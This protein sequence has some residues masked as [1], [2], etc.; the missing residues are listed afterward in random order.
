MRDESLE[1]V[2]GWLMQLRTLEY[3]TLSRCWGSVPLP[4]LSPPALEATKLG[5][6]MYYNSAVTQDAVTEPG[7]SEDLP[8]PSRHENWEFDVLDMEVVFRSNNE[9]EATGCSDTTSHGQLRPASYFRH[10]TP[11]W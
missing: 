4:Y 1:V 9:V 7:G 2:W 3:F 11:Q 6:P 8:D 10:A 5:R